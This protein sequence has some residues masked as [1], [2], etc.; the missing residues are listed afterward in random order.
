MFLVSKHELQ[1]SLSC[2]FDFI[3]SI[4]RFFWL[5][6]PKFFIR[7]NNNKN[8]VAIKSSAECRVSKGL[9]PDIKYNDVLT[10]VNLTETKNRC[11]V[12]FE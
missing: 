2:F 10:N 11:V 9:L 7:I 6:A 1:L 4:E 8:T 3:S 5:S 12:C